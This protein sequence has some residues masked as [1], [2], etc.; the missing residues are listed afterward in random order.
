MGVAVWNQFQD[1]FLASSMIS[2]E[3]WYRFSNVGSLLSG[4]KPQSA[5]A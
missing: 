5:V 3:L 2:T 1:L 4:P